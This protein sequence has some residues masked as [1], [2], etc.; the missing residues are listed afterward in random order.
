M[1]LRVSLSPQKAHVAN[2]IMRSLARRINVARP[3]LLGVNTKVAESLNSVGGAY[4]LSHHALYDY[5]KFILVMTF[6]TMLLYSIHQIRCRTH[7]QV[8]SI[9]V[10]ELKLAR[11]LFQLTA[12][13]GLGS[14]RPEGSVST[15]TLNPDGVRTQTVK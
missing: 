11:S 15:D 1:L 4:L 9:N 10:I 2:N 7:I 6:Y 8:S 12:F 5:N 14:F 3:P 13:Y